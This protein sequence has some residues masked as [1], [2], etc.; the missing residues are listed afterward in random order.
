MEK[1]LVLVSVLVM[2]A[3]AYAMPNVG[4]DAIFA[5][6]STLAGQT[7][8]G[9][10]EFALMG[11]DPTTNTWSEQIT[12]VIGGQ[13][14]TQMRS[15]SS[16][17]LMTD[18]Q[19]QSILANCTLTGGIPA[20]ITVPAGSFNTCAIPATNGQATGTVWISD[21]AFGI[22]QEEMTNTTTGQVVIMQLQSQTPGQ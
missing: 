4:D 12:S 7:E 9:S 10:I 22:V 17:E 19:A 15:A 2:S 5:V 14:S 6:T 13:T 18:A 11:Q 16:Q 20:A 1:I 3:S 21:V 8:N